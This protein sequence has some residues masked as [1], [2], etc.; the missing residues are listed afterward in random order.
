MPNVIAIVLESLTCLW[1][2]NAF[3]ITGAVLGGAYLI[4]GYKL[5]KRQYSYSSSSSSYDD[6]VDNALNDY[7]GNFTAGWTALKV[8]TAV[9]AIN[10]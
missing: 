1:W 7:Y 8:A 6:I 3:A 2:L 10:W 5:A 9:A 4:G